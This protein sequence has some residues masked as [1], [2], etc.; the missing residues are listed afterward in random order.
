MDYLFQDLR[1]AIRMLRKSPVTT[2]VAIVS[3]ALGIGANSAIF[4]LMSALVLRPLPVR[5][6]ARLVRIATQ[7]PSDATADGGL[8]LSIYEAIRKKNSV[9]EDLFA[10]TAGGIVNL[11]ANGVKYA[12]SINTV[13][14]E[15][16]ST[17]GIQP[18]L[19]RP[20]TPADLSLDSGVPA[21][22]AV[23]GYGCWQR[24]FHGDP[25]VVGKT[26]LVE[27]HPLT[28]I[29]VAPES[30]AG[31]MIDAAPEVIIPIGYSGRPS[32]RERSILGLDVIARMKPGVTIE[33]AQAQLNAMWPALLESYLPEGFTGPQRDAFLKTRVVL[34]SASKG[35]SFMRNRF[36]S[37]LTILMAMV[38][39]LLMIACAN[40]ANLM[41]ARATGRQ[42]EFGIRVALGAN[43]WRILRLLLT[44]SLLLT[45]TG[46]ALGLV[47][48]SWVSRA[49][50][51]A[52]WTGFIPLDLD[53]APDWRVLAFTAGVSLCTGLLFG[54]SPV[55]G[56][57]RT[58]PGQR[59]QQTG[60]AV[61]A[62]SGAMGRVLIGGQ[63][64]LSLI[65]VIGAV[66]FVRS[67]G[68]LHS[69]EL[70]FNHDRWLVV[71]L[72]PQKGSAAQ[73][74]PNRAAYYR[75]LVERLQATPGIQSVSYSHMGP[76][77]GFE[78]KQSVTAANAR[79]QAMYE[80]AGPGFF[81]MA[82]M[83]VLAGREFEW[84]DDE[85]APPVA[86]ISES[87]ARRLYPDGRAVGQRI[88][89]G[90]RKNLEIVGVV[91]SAS[92]W[93][94]QS[95]EPLAVYMAF[96]QA[97]DYNSSNL[98]V[99][100]KGDPTAAIPAVREVL[101]S[102][103]RHTILVAQTLEQRSNRMLVT[104]RMIAILGSFFGALALLLASIGIYGL[105]T[106]AVARRT[107]EIGLR[108]ALGARASE[109]VGLILKEVLWMVAAG[110]AVAIPVALMAAKLI[111]GLLYGVAGSDPSVI[112]LSCSI[113]V[114]AAILA[115]F[116]P[117]RRAAR[118]DPMTALRAE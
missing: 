82:G 26:F 68:N 46:A 31:P 81:Q 39:L 12:S 94:P 8:S 35:Q 63:M 72:F 15:Y 37:S 84:R 114:A 50:L 100:T 69:T 83:H 22:V 75:D 104:E 70:G 102:L 44:E 111:Q 33:Q 7:R 90:N 76:V 34:S 2:L 74:F 55:W 21:P 20:I 99:R 60:R 16:F 73:Q 109:V 9:F 103:G 98:D 25:G 13:T 30:F 97:Q 1:Y 116:V 53:A 66:V 59:M 57:F 24:R 4:S 17:F 80:V 41:I 5:E 43:R 64:A 92:L 79:E 62:G 49:M 28:I 38:G 61:R 18:I 3:L 86:I 110:I 117:A 89:F 113:L 67:M 11:E 19:G 36:S 95:R 10:Y 85:N 6:P 88:D 106:H 29:G 91:N 112:L 101:Q 47:A 51:H 108:M 65:L 118:I 14:G 45:A 32:Y 27:D 52:M 87:L 54:A 96:L 71:Q 40:L 23:L 77:I 56:L 107:S 93:K 115:A 42:G 48:S 105:M 78:Y 58:D